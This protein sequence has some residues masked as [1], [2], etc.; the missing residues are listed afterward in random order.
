MRFYKLISLFALSRLF[1]RPAR[2]MKRDAT[3]SRV[4]VVAYDY[5][6]NLKQRV[7]SIDWEVSGCGEHRL[8]GSEPVE[9]HPPEYQADGTPEESSLCGPF[10]RAVD[11]YLDR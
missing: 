6:L 9:S 2:A 3:D 1:P 7:M 10:N 5:T 8:E 4:A 11:V